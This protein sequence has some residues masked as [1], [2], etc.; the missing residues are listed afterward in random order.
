MQKAE[1]LCRCCKAMRLFPPAETPLLLLEHPRLC[2]Q[3]NG[4]RQKATHDR[5]DHH[6][7]AIAHIDDW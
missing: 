2:S 1:A 4:E 5:R 7:V 6:A 3:G